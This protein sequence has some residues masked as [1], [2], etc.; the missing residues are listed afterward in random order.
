MGSLNP[1][2]QYAH[3]IGVPTKSCIAHLAPKSMTFANTRI[4]LCPYDEHHLELQMGLFKFNYK[5]Y[6][7]DGPAYESLCPK[8]GLTTVPRATASLFLTAGRPVSFDVIPV[9]PCSRFSSYT[10]CSLPRNEMVRT[11]R[12]IATQSVLR[13]H[14]D[15]LL[16]PRSLSAL[17]LPSAQFSGGTLVRAHPSARRGALVADGQAVWFDG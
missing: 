13:V 8:A 12:M 14:I 11:V 2:W 5:W 4:R 9:L 1:L 10:R 15:L 7:S 17:P 16:L 3:T 6:F